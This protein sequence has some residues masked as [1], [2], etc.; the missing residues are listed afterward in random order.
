MRDLSIAIDWTESNNSLYQLSISG[1]RHK[2]QAN[3]YLAKV[4]EKIDPDKADE[5]WH[6]AMEDF[7]VIKAATWIVDLQIPR[8]QKVPG[9]QTEEEY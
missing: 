2:I 6:S 5:L 1:H 7:K 8:T 3:F 4:F 9:K